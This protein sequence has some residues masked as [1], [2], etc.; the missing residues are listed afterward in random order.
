MANN[1]FLFSS[2]NKK[3]VALAVVVC[4]NRFRETLVLIK[5]AIIFSKKC[6][7]KVI[8]IAEP[9]LILTFEETVCYV[10]LC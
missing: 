7:L 5:S 1:F 4:G 3:N 2:V 10:V 9:E 8:I 6:N